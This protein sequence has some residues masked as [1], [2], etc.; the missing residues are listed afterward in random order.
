MLM[1]RR[2]NN[3]VF[4]GLGTLLHLLKVRGGENYSQVMGRF[5]REPYNHR[6]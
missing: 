1:I 4:K 6:A 3:E 5:C 2:K